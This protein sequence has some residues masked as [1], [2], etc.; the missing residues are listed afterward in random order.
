MGEDGFALLELLAVFAIIAE[1][2]ALKLPALNRA[3][4]AGQS[5]SDFLG[6]I[7]HL[8]PAGRDHLGMHAAQSQLP[9]FR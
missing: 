4:E 9:P 5:A 2:A 7:A 6:P 1:L 3:R 8:H